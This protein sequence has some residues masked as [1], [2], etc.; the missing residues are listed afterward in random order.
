MRTARG[1]CRWWGSD[2]GLGV[3]LSDD[4][5]AVAEAEVGRRVAHML[6]SWAGYHC[7]R[8]GTGIGGFD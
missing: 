3:E 2:I 8:D 4:V 6:L 1:R 7:V 5:V